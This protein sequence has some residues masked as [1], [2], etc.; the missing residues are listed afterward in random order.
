MPLEDSTY[1]IIWYEQTLLYRTMGL[2][3]FEI[4]FR[5]IQI[6]AESGGVGPKTKGWGALKDLGLNWGGW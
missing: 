5:P 3:S 1:T 2:F 4:K 6:S